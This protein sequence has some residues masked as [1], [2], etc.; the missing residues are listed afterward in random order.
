MKIFGW[1]PDEDM[2][3][4][5]PPT[6]DAELQIDSYDSMSREYW[7]EMLEGISDSVPEGTSIAEV[8]CG[9]FEG[10]FCEYFDE[11]DSYNGEWL[12]SYPDMAIYATLVCRKDVGKKYREE[13]SRI[14]STLKENR[15]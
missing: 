10:V 3:I 6:Q 14:F 4:L 13:V 7:L 2:P 11:E 12:L 9:D 8:Q 1:L 15:P 5:R